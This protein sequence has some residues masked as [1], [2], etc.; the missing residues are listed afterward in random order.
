MDLSNSLSVGSGSSLGLSRRESISCIG[1]RNWLQIL[2]LGSS[3]GMRLSSRL[4]PGQVL[5]SGLDLS[6]SLGLG[7]I[8]SLGLD[9]RR[10]LGLEQNFSLSVS[11]LS[12]RDTLE[13]HVVIVIA[14]L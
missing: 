7:Q 12:L 4:G 1:P 8:Q 2:H 6:L 11:G 9:H 14:G 5:S 13:A 10:R 3:P